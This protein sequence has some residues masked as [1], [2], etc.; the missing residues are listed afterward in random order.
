MPPIDPTLNTREWATI[1]RVLPRDVYEEL[2]RFEELV[3]EHSGMPARFQGI[4]QCVSVWS[5]ITHA[6]RNREAELI[7]LAKEWADGEAACKT[8]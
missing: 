7:Q 2:V 8:E 1:K 4:G 5:V 6:L 3:A